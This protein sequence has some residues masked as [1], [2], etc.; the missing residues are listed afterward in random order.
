MLRSR[1][2]NEG[3]RERGKKGSRLPASGEL[4]GLR[5]ARLGGG[6]DSQKVWP[7]RTNAL[8]WEAIVPQ[9]QGG[10]TG[11]GTEVHQSL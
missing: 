3:E 7:D 1:I 5:D 4:P 2:K 11:L 6:G 8:A 9:V 10:V